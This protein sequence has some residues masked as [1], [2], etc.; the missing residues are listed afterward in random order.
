MKISTTPFDLEGRQYT[1]LCATDVSGEQ[2]RK[3][4]E[5]VLFEGVLGGT[6]EI[7][8]RAEELQSAGVEELHLFREDTS[9]FSHTLVEEIHDHRLLMAAEKGELYIHPRNVETQDMLKAVVCLF[10]DRE[11]AKGR[12]LQIHRQAS[13]GVLITDPTLLKLI[14]GYMVKNALEA[15]AENETVTLN[16]DA[17]REE[18]EFSVQNPHFIPKDV[19][20]QIFQRGFTTKGEGRGL[21]TYAM[22]LL[23]EKYLKGKVSFVSTKNVGTTFRACYPPDIEGH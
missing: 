5:R 16:V 20:L 3:V 18:V 8:Q 7:G 4:L 11:E 10:E 9:Q 6:K 1:I 14:L 12:I 22:K 19:Q 21:G 15:C 13:E 17:R 23:S 2:R